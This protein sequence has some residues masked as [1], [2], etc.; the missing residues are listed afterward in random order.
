MVKLLQEAVNTGSDEAYRAY[1]DHVAQHAPTSV[2][3]LMRVLPLG[4]PVPLGRGRAG[5][6]DRQ[7]VRRDRDVARLA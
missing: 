4:E 6:I 2:R 3:D 7:A 5:R 1:R